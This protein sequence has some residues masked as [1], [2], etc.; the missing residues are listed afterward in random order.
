MVVGISPWLNHSLD[1]QIECPWLDQRPNRILPFSKPVDSLLLEMFPHAPRIFCV[2][3]Y[4]SLLPPHVSPDPSARRQPF[5]HPVQMAASLRR[6][7]IPRG[8]YH[9]GFLLPLAGTLYCHCHLQ[10]WPFRCPSQTE[11]VASGS[12][13]KE[14]KKI[15]KEVRKQIPEVPPRTPDLT[16][17]L[18]S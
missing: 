7:A 14:T 15:G 9:H 1:F 8:A 3:G 10:R 6:G 18:S 13:A 16:R 17:A 4:L 11:L 2:S 5:S 12:R